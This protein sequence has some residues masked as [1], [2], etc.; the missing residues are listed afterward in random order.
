MSTKTEFIGFTF[1]GIHSSAFNAVVTID[2]RL[3][4]GLT[5]EF[6]HKTTTIPGKAGA[7]YWGTDIGNR[8][9]DIPLAF[10]GVTSSQ[11]SQMKKW[12]APD[13]VGQLIFDESPYM[14]HMVRVNSIPIMEVVPFETTTRVGISNAAS[15]RQHLYNGEIK[16]QFIAFEPYGTGVTA[17][18]PLLLSSGNFPG[19]W[20]AS[21]RLPYYFN[22]GSYTTVMVTPGTR[23]QDD[24]DSSNNPLQVYQGGDAPAPLTISFAIGGSPTTPITITNLSLNKIFTIGALSVLNADAL[25]W[26]VYIKPLTGEVIGHAVSSTNASGVDTYSKYVLNGICVGVFPYVQNINPPYIGIIT[27][28]DATHASIDPASASLYARNSVALDRAYLLGHD[29]INGGTAYAQYISHA[30]SDTLLV[31]TTDPIIFT[32]G[33]VG[34]V[35]IPNLFH[36]SPSVYEVAVTYSYKYQ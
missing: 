9:F 1:D 22:M 23:T 19:W 36:I 6:T 32:G 14:Y 26:H 25:H 29:G 31:T 5:P 33:R 21:G 13:N 20:G 17:L 11:L 34:M 15:F 16:L 12:L 27:R 2:N 35:I 24:W 3:P 28:A 8:I 18:S 4:I 7:L 10:T 30:S